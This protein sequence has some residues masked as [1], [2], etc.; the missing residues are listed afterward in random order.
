MPEWLLQKDN[1]IPPKTGD[2]FINKSILSILGVLSKL[3]FHQE[4]AGKRA[5]VD[6]SIKFISTMIVIL[7]TALSRSFLFVFVVDAYLLLN[8]GLLSVKQIRYIL[9]MGMIA[10]IFSFIILLPSI[11]MGNINGLLIIIKVLTTVTALNILTST[12]SW[13]EI[14]SSLKLLYIPDIF[15]L[16]LDITMKYILIL[17]EFS[18]NMLYALKLKSI[19]KS[20]SKGT[21]L[22]GIVGTMF[23]KS[24]DMAE[25]MYGAMECRGFTGEYRMQ[26]KYKFR[27][28]EVFF[29]II[30]IVF[31]IIY[32]YFDRL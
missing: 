19:G 11:V 3:G 12:A 28:M 4:N 17:G 26:R 31:I 10:F 6:P 27:V 32:F 13:N 15:I 2:A 7:L 30:N 29:V 18:L 16:V 24:K 20:S 21:S 5:L 25:E 8:V 9:R 1:Y 14:T 23:I 22:S